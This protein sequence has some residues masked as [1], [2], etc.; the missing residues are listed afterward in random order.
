[1]FPFLLASS[2]TAVRLPSPKY[3]Y[4]GHLQWYPFTA[5]A[6]IVKDTAILKTSFSIKQKTIHAIHS[7]H[8]QHTDTGNEFCGITTL[9]S[10]WG[11][12]RHSRIID[13]PHPKR[14]RKRK[15]ERFTKIWTI[16]IS[17]RKATFPDIFRQRTR[18]IQRA[19]ANATMHRAYGQDQ[20]CLF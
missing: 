10:F 3:V 12:I 1:M 14:K 9:L 11:K 2:F 6:H 15:K 18:P 20:H 17:S 8:G 7:R 5:H 13:Y 19:D 4:A 16:P